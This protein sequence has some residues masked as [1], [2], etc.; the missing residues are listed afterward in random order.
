MKPLR[1]W[2]PINGIKVEIIIPGEYVESIMVPAAEHE[3]GHIVAAHH[4][5]ARVLGIAVGFRP[6]LSHRDMFLQALY[7]GKG[8]TVA[9]QCVVKAAG[10]AA[11]ILF[12]GEFDEVGARGDL[13]DVEALTGQPTL[14]PYLDEAKRI[15]KLYP[16]EFKCIAS[17]LRRSF[18]AEAD[19]SMG[20]LPG[21]YMG[22]LLLDDMQLMECLSKTPDRS[23]FGSISVGGIEN[24]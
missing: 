3:A 19:R 23:C 1:L 12:H 18:E 9:N 24:S 16:T 17:A 7:V 15:L 20:L 10:P 14:A 11:D 22:T 4:L 13:Q 8:L 5:N 2:L 21:N 6:D